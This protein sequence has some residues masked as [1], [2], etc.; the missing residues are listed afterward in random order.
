MEPNLQTHLAASIGHRETWCRIQ[1]AG[2]HIMESSVFTFSH[3][4]GVTAVAAERYCVSEAFEFIDNQ[5]R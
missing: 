5:T 1:H 3:L 4:W 2:R